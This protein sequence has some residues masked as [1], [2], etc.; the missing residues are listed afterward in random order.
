MNLQHEE[1]MD[2]IRRMGRRHLTLTRLWPGCRAN[3]THQGAPQE[4]IT[5]TEMI[6]GKS[7]HQ[8]AK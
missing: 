6:L 3:L 8:A 1:N 5:W 2:R 7:T 4:E